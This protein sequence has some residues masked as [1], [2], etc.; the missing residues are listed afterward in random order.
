VLP[1]NGR[2]V[3]VWRHEQRKPQLHVNLEVAP[4]SQ[5]DAALA[6]KQRVDVATRLIKD[7]WF[8]VLLVIGVGVLLRRVLSH[9]PQAPRR[10]QHW[11]ESISGGRWSASCATL[12][13]VAIV[14]SAQHAW[15]VTSGAV[16]AAAWTGY[17]T[18]SQ[19]RRGRF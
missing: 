1:A 15:F 13:A 19:I 16:I 2:I 10:A 17:A 18:I 4:W 7:A 14:G 8:V 5:P 6:D 3:G 11:T 9:T 12:I